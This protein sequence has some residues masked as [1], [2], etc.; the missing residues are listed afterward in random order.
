ETQ[1]LLSLSL[2]N[3]KDIHFSGERS[4]PKALVYAI[5]GLGAFILLIACFN[6]VNLNIAY[7]F[8]RSRELGVR[9]TLGAFKGQLFLQLWGEAFLLYFLG[10]VIGIGLAYQLLPVFNAQFD[11]G[12]QIST[13]FRPSFIALMLGVFIL[14]SLIAGG[15]PA[16]MM[17]NFNQRS[18]EHTSELQSREH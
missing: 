14:F 4:A 3:I 1:E 17:S 12:I 9:K 10:F 16:L 5:M 7:S 6:F 11:V 18:E 8:K 2:T 13:L 15:Y